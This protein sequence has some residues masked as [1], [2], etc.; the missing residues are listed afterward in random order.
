M[1]R[2]LVLG[3]GQSSPYLIRYLLDGAEDN[4]WFV[5]VGDRDIRLAKSRVGDH[6][7]GEA[8]RLDINDTHMLSAQIRAADMV[9]NFLPA[10]F[11]SLIGRD[12]VHNETSMVS[13]SYRN[14][15][16]RAIHRDARR[17]G[18]LLL[19]EMGLDPGLDLMSAMTMI[20]RVQHDG[21]IIESFESYGGGVAAPDGDDNPLRYVI[22]WNPRNVVMSGEAGAQF[23][24]QGRI[25][26][27]PWHHVF[28]RTWMID[29][30]GVGPME[31]YPNRDSISYRETFGLKDVKTLIRGTLRYPGWSETWQQIVHLGLPNEHLRIPGL[32]DRTWKEIVAMFLPRDVAAQAPIE[33][34]VAN[35]LKVSPTGSII[36]NLTWLGLFSDKPT[37]CKGETVTD[38]L[39]ELL[40]DKLQLLPDS[41]DLVVLYHRIHARYPEQNDRTEVIT[42]TFTLEGEPGGLTAMARTVGQPAAVAAK[43]LL[44][45]E[46]PLTGC[47]IPTLPAIYKPIL[48]ELEKDGLK[49]REKVLPSPPENGPFNG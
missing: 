2:I 44:A 42:S 39:V 48:R 40:E 6:A 34:R 37:G 8:I 49:F 15:D 12:C 23:L 26:I 14:A 28:D 16:I 3:A 7:W 38:A 9:V 41:R 47:H 4:G 11:L 32:K 10:K 20:H 29:V 22:T 19:C 31:G 36:R 13:V 46:F 17:Q 18:V 45:G 24:N 35:Y 27:V 21:G 1:K 25:K 43:L 30:D 33:Q 5:T